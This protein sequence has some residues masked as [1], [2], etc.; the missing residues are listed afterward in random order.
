MPLFKTDHLTPKSIQKKRKSNG[1]QKFL[2]QN[3]LFEQKIKT[4][5]RCAK[6]A[7]IDN[8]Q[9]LIYNDNNLTLKRTVYY[10][11]L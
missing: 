11:T 1:S 3:P 10:A 2:R 7:Q 6:H 4:R 5:L 8:F 9:D